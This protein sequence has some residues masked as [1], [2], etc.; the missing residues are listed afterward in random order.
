M[1]E[2]YVKGVAHHHGP[3]SCASRPR[4]G[5]E[6]LTGESAGRVWSSEITSLGKPTALANRE[7]H[8]T[9]GVRREPAVVPAESKTPSMRGH[10]MHGNRETPSA[11]AEPISLGGSIREDLWSSS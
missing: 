8:V 10:P 2:P 1:R 7:G 11:S 6:A 4:G 5:R 3:E 9:V